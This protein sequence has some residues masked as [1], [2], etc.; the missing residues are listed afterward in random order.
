VTCSDGKV[1]RLYLYYNNLSGSLPAEIDKLMNLEVLRL[2]HNDICG[3][4][5]AS[6]TT[7]AHL[8]YVN[9]NYNHL[10]ATD[11]VKLWLEDHGPWDDS[12][13]SSCP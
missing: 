9:L 2:E 6:V 4:V 5:P 7:L 11:P 13:Q 8:W 1:T 3:S 10:T 12:T